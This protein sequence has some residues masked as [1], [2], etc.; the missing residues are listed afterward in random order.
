MEAKLPLI[1]AAFSS[2]T[3]IVC[4]YSVPFGQYTY[5]QTNTTSYSTLVFG[6]STN[7]S[8]T[9]SIMNPRQYAN[10][11]NGTSYSTVYSANVTAGSHVGQVNI[12]PGSYFLVI[13][14]SGPAGS[15]HAL[16]YTLNS[17]IAP[18]GKVLSI[19]FSNMYVLPF[20]LSNYS[21]MQLNMAS[22]SPLNV[23][24]P[25][26]IALSNASTP[27]NHTAYFNNSWYYTWYNNRGSYNITLGSQGSSNVLLYL[28]SMPALVNPLNPGIYNMSSS[29]SLPEG[30]ASYGL[31]NT[32]GNLSPYQI[33]TNEVEGIAKL[34]EAYAY[35]A[36]P[37]YNLSENGIISLQLNAVLNIESN[38][39]T[40]AY[41]LQDVLRMDT[42]NMS[43]SLA[44]NIWNNT[45]YGGSTSNATLSGN[46]FSSPVNYSQESINFYGYTSNTSKYSYPLVFAP[47]MS[48][49]YYYGKPIVSFGTY[50]SSGIQYF[51]SVTFNITSDNASFLLTP[52]YETQ[53]GN[54]YDFELVFGGD[55]NGS[56]TT[57]SKMASNLWL[58]YYSGNT[59]IQV[60]TAYTFGLDTEES[61]IGLKTIQNASGA[62]VTLGTMNKSKVIYASSNF[63][64]LL[65]PNAMYVVPP[66]SANPGGYSWPNTG[67]TGIMPGAPGQIASAKGIYW[68]AAAL[69]LIVII[70][71]IVLLHILA[72]GSKKPPDR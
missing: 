60:P 52:F 13:E 70:F 26:G 27:L 23:T 54:F 10:F 16:N 66:V 19:N 5:L 62:F 2:V 39:K 72:R 58:Y 37:G 71:V 12:S 18:M 46:G 49:S 67:P 43:Y 15:T 63:S 50:S 55:A 65:A 17:F 29:N 69:V 4:A 1:L 21:L 28:G 64:S 51:D 48:V 38:G 35:N 7:Y 42:I 34:D 22:S 45:A 61:A 36:M 9:I 59:Q 3:G 32:S 68:A 57:F 14:G 41:W 20:Y 11:S 25:A 33:R 53:S 40:Y 30:I 56:A 6:Y 24:F 31:R 44:D 47:V 8:A